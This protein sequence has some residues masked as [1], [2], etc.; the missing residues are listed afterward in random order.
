M[1]K[2]F[3]S[4]ICCSY[5]DGL[6]SKDAIASKDVAPERNTALVKDI[7]IAAVATKVAALIL[8]DKRQRCFYQRCS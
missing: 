5:K 8:L 7:V 1:F 3:P 4:K 2:N 6:I